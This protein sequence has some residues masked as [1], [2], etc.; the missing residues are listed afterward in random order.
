MVSRI[1][2]TTIQLF[3]FIGT[4]RT[5]GAVRRRLRK[6]KTGRLGRNEV[7]YR[8]R[9]SDET[10]QGRKKLYILLSIHKFKKKG[11]RKAIFITVLIFFIKEGY[12]QRCPMD[13]VSQWQTVS[14]GADVTKQITALTELV[15]SADVDISEVEKKIK[16]GKAKAKL[17]LKWD[18]NKTVKKKIF[19]ETV[20]DKTVW[21]D[22]Q[23]ASRA[24]CA[25]FS[26]IKLGLYR[27]PEQYN[28]ALKQLQEAREYLLSAKKKAETPT[29]E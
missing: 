9:S 23:L 27:T 20:W 4:L 22:I 13:N 16:G 29:T 19:K 6:Y 3:L 24:Y 11:M 5:T 28:S 14:K 10:R 15:A 26:E 2:T 8:L 17:D 21:H 25:L 1:L 12:S 18:L 7:I